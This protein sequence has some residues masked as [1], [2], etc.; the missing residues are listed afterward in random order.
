MHEGGR[1]LNPFPADF[2]YIASLP[3]LLD[4]EY[5]CTV[6][7]KKPEN[8]QIILIIICGRSPRRMVGFL[9]DPSLPGLLR[10]AGK[11]DLE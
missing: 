5:A 10:P 7:E 9:C 11:L 6:L 1:R 2:R 4:I 3:T 8:P